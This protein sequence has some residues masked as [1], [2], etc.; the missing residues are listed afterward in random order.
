M[1]FNLQTNKALSAIKSNTKKWRLVQEELNPH[2]SRL[3]PYASKE[4]S[5]AICAILFN[6]LSNACV[7]N[8]LRWKN[9]MKFYNLAYRC[10]GQLETVDSLIEQTLTT[11]KHE[12]IQDWVVRINDL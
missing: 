11:F 8:R 10:T 3:F 9:D 1:K 2:I 5:I 6:R 12:T 4:E 7:R